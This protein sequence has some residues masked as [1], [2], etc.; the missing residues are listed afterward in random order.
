MSPPIAEE[1]LIYIGQILSLAIS[2]FVILKVDKMSGAVFLVA[3]LL[4]NQF[5]VINSLDLIPEPT[6]SRGA[7]WARLHDYYQCMPLI[8]RVAIHG[9]QVGVILYSLAIYLLARKVVAKR[10]NS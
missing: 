6:E 3:W 5:L 2:V 8:E 9:T 7:C 1:S 10:E 4:H